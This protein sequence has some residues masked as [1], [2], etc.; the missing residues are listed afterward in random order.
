MSEN[1]LLKVISS[2]ENCDQEISQL[3]ISQNG[4]LRVMEDISSQNNDEKLEIFQNN[5]SQSNFSHSQI[6]E[7]EELLNWNSQNHLTII[8][9]DENEHDITL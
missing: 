2:Q 3:D 5:L 4:L 8:N 7:L 1:D 6:D 9:E